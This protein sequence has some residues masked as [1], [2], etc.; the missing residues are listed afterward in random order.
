MTMTPIA[1]TKPTAHLVTVRRSA[2]DPGELIG[3][4]AADEKL[5]RRMAEDIIRQRLGLPTSISLF[6]EVK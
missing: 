3:V 6:A 4:V 2:K 1:V 5:A